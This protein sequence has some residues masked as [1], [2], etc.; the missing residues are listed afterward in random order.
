MTSLEGTCL[1]CG[2]RRDLH[3]AGSFCC[4]PCRKAWGNRRM[5][6]GAELYDLYMVLRYDRQTG[7]EIGAFQAINRLVSIFRQEDNRER[8]GRRSWRP[9]REVLLDRPSLK[10]MT[11]RIRAGR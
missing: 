11:T 3:R 6:R 2:G 1:E 5:T 9:P 10:T 4:T 7:V 8:A